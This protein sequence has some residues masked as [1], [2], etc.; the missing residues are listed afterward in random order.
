MK[1]RWDIDV[2]LGQWKEPATGI[3]ELGLTSIMIST[4]LGLLDRSFDRVGYNLRKCCIS[5]NAPI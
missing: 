4:A 2:V 5:N 1:E 3:A